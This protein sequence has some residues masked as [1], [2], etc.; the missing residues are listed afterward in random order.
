MS[1]IASLDHIIEF[2]WWERQFHD[3]CCRWYVAELAIAH[4]SEESL[5]TQLAQAVMLPAVGGVCHV[6][7][8]GLNITEVY[9]SL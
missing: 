1:D 5:W 7:M 3:E 4:A 8:H 9:I 6:W 2:S